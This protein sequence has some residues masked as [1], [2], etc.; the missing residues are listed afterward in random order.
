VNVS[1][2]SFGER[3]PRPGLWP[4]SYHLVLFWFMLNDRRVPFAVLAPLN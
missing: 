3:L 2:Y 4:H 1:F